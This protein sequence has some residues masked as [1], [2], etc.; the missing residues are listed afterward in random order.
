MPDV[1]IAVLGVQPVTIRLEAT[2]LVGVGSAAWPRLLLRFKIQLAL[3]HGHEAGTS[4]VLLRLA[5]RIETAKIG[6]IAHFDFGPI[7]GEPPPHPFFAPLDITVDLDRARVWQLEEAR[8][9]ADAQLVFS[10]SGVAWLPGSQRFELAPSAGQLQTRVPRSYWVDE[11]VSRWGLSSVKV[12]E[13]SFPSSKVGDNFR[14]AYARVESAERLF[15]NGQYKQVLTEL[16]LAFEGL[17]NSL[18]FDDRVKDCLDHLFAEFGGEKK[19][20][21]RESVL[22]LYRFLHM[23]PHQVLQTPSATGQTAITRSDARFALVMTYAVFEYIT[24]KA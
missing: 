13:I 24:P 17:A 21:A 10:F 22:N 5:G 23:G 20:K 2:D 8:A 19:D 4:Y 18:G 15:A 3:P 9:G 11:V 16:R 1:G 12:V 7:V 6:E 14:S